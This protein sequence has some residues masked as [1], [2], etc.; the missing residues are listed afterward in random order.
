[1]A[2]NEN[3]VNITQDYYDSEDADNFYF[4]VWGGEDIHIGIYKPGDPISTASKRSVETMAGMI[5]DLDKEKKILDIGAGYGGAA[6]FLVSHY[7]CEVV[8]LNL[9]EV[10]NDRNKKKNV[11]LGLDQRISVI[12]GNFENLPFENEQFDV[13]WCEDAILHSDQKRKVFEEVHRVLKP[14]GQFIFSDPM[15]SDNCPEDVLAPVLARIHLKEMGSVKLYKSFARQLGW[16]ELDIKEMPEQLVNHYSN[17]LQ[18][19]EEKY[20]EL[21]TSCS[22]EYMTNMK[23]GLEH[24]IDAGKK[25]YLNWGFLHF[26]K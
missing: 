23:K 10:E 11:S 8:C 9:S 19:L 3:L 2:E 15:Q 20:D 22:Q 14:G 12:A 13:V 25:Q 18:K 6:R 24:W 16:E 7:P 4:Q 21:S 1:M 5:H 17:V 26:R